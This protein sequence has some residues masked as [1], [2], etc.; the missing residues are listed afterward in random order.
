MIYQTLP[1]GYKAVFML[2]ST[3]HEIYPPHFNIYQQNKYTL[4]ALRV[5]IKQIGIIRLIK[6]KVYLGLHGFCIQSANPIDGTLQS[7][8]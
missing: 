6:N 7:I 2:N 5:N 3:Q 4:Y 8:F 1:S